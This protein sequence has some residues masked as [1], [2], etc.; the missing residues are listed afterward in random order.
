MSHIECDQ[1]MCSG[2]LACVIAC[3]D[4]HYDE[5]E[6]NAVSSIIYEKRKSDHSDWTGYTVRS[7]MHCA[8]A[9]CMEACPN[10]A[11]IRDERG[12]V[13]AVS[14]KCIGCKMCAKVC[15]YDVPRFD[16]NGKIIKCDGCSVRIAYGMAP[17]CVRI[18]NTGALTIT[19]E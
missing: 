7:C 9:K 13:I 6:I 18:C 8:D 10:E 2:C 16:Q 5:T 3:I 12:F 17:A 4:Q 1:H 14:E 15:P 11:L 19:E